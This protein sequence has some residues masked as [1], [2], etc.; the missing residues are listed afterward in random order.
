MRIKKIR[1]QGFRLLRD[2]ELL[3]EDTATVVVG[4]TTAGRRL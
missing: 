3:L 1:V 4:E 2:V